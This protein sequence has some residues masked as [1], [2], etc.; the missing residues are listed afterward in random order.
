MQFLKH[1]ILTILQHFNQ[2]DPRLDV[3]LV[4][5]YYLSL[6]CKF[7]ITCRSKSPILIASY[8]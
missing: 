8:T 2:T 3:I 1:K 5:F 4:D 6:I 7:V